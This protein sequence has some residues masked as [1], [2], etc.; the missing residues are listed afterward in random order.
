VSAVITEAEV[1][2]TG[3][4]VLARLRA[5]DF[6]SPSSEAART[7]LRACR[8][9]LQE[10][11]EDYEDVKADRICPCAIFPELEHDGEAHDIAL[12]KLADDVLAW[13]RAAVMVVAQ[14]CGDETAEALRAGEGGASA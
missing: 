13:A 4:T 10:S 9:S 8:D 5:D 3:R 11:L 6:P 12:R 7:S 14:H 1:I 2:G